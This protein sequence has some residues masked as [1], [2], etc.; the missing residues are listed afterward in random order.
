[1]SAGDPGKV[2]S[3]GEPGKAESRVEVLLAALGRPQDRWPKREQGE[4][5]LLLIEVKDGMVGEM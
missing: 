4:L 1:M 2:E 3:A 5:A